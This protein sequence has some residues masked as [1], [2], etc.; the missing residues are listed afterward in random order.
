MMDNDTIIKT[1]K[2]HHDFND[3]DTSVSMRE[4]YFFLTLL[5]SHV[6]QNIFTHITFVVSTELI[7]FR[8]VGMQFKKFQKFWKKQRPYFLIITF[9][10]GCLLRKIAAK[11][12]EIHCFFDEK[13]LFPS[14]KPT[15][16]FMSPH[17]LLLLCDSQP[18]LASQTSDSCSRGISQHN[19]ISFDL[20]A[21][22]FHIK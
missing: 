5:S 17:I 18:P 1:F 15:G 21:M 6:N 3:G 8:L 11:C 10:E 22:C 12:R 20:P 7:I 4:K 14:L 9:I 2:P 13:T 19:H 16:V